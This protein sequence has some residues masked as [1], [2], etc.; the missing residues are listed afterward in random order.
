M[1]SIGQGNIASKTVGIAIF[2]IAIPIR[3]EVP[4][5]KLLLAGGQLARLGLVDWLGVKLFR[6]RWDRLVSR[7]ADDLVLGG[8]GFSHADL[9]RTGGA[10]TENKH[11]GR[12]TEDWC[13]FHG[14]LNSLRWEFWSRSIMFCKIGRASCRERGE[15]WGGLGEVKGG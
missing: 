7:G 11:Y 9:P 5:F 2:A 4:A 15:M 8:R 12:N 10:G 14:L 3:A 13:Q 1:V 6:L